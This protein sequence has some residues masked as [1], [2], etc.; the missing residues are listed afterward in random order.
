MK[1]KHSSRCSHTC[2]EKRCH[3][4]HTEQSQGVDCS[5]W[6]QWA[7]KAT[8]RRRRPFMNIKRAMRAS[9]EQ[10]NDLILSEAVDPRVQAFMIL[11]TTDP[12]ESDSFFLSLDAADPVFDGP[13]LGSSQR[14]SRQRFVG[15]HLE[16]DVIASMRAYSKHGYREAPRQ[17]LT[18]DQQPKKETSRK[19]RPRSQKLVEMEEKPSRLPSPISSSP[20]PIEGLSVTPSM[21]SKQM[22]ILLTIQQDHIS[23]TE[24]SSK[25][26]SASFKSDWKEAY[27]L[28]DHKEPKPKSTSPEGLSTDDDAFVHVDTPAEDELEI[29]FGGQPIKVIP[30]ANVERAI[31]AGEKMLS[32]TCVSCE[33]TL[34]TTAD[35]EMVYCPVCGTLAPTHIMNRTPH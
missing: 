34:L 10:Q 26:E 17:P 27:K 23:N 7:L 6:M 28:Q 3:I 18:D 31:H 22:A 35:T 11:P 20:S 5:L 29:A 15:K 1:S 21:I 13:P 33:N 25:T 12:T 14:G 19:T 2:S 30:Q 32:L 4:K 24:K 9:K 8:G 16:S